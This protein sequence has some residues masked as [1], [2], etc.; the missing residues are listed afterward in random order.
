M[1]IYTID[2]ETYY[3]KEFSLSKLTTEQYIRDPRFHVILVVIRHPD[4]TMQRITGTH[5]EI[6]YALDVIPFGESAALAHNARFDASILEWVFDIHP[7]VWL[8]TL[9]MARAMFG[10]RGNGLA[11]LAK[12]YGLQDKTEVVHAMLGRTRESLTG[13]ELD[14]YFTYCQNDTDLCW[15]LYN[16]MSQGWYSTDPID[17]R[18]EYPQKELQLIDLTIKMYTRPRLRL[19]VDKLTTHLA[20]VKERKVKLLESVGCERG[21]LLSN[22]QFANLLIEHGVVPPTK[23]SPTTGKETFAF[24]KTDDGLKALAEHPDEAVQ[25]L[26]AA[27]L[28]VKSTLEETRTEA[29]IDIAGHTPQ[30]ILPIPLKY[31]YAVTKRFAGDDGINMQ[32]LPSR[33]V[34]AKAIKSCILAPPG[35]VLIDADSSNIEARGLAWLACQYD[36]VEDFRNKVD[37][38]N[39][40]ASKIYGREIRRKERPEDEQPGFVGKTVTLGCGYMTGAAKLQVTLRASTPS[41]D[42]PLEW[43]QAVIKTYRDSVPNICALWKQADTALQAMHDNCSMWLGREGVVYVDGKRG[44]RLPSGLY[45]HYP[46]LHRGK[47]GWQYKSETGLKHIYG[48]KVVENVVQALARIVV[49][50]QM[51]RIARRYTVSM[52]VHDSVIALALESEL[53]AAM[54]YVYEC[55]RWVPKWAT[56]WPLDCEA[57]YGYNYGEIKL[58]D[59]K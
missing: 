6:K 43:C 59:S 54:Q 58:Y 35:Y 45:I 34:N 10:M 8:D 56:G 24:A 9:S 11:A 46:Q 36:M 33:G 53:D 38:Y 48:G 3:D 26:V 42:M 50:E 57:K 28:G 51:L 1:D 47:E 20:A 7:K 14:Q 52:T 55:M 25:A 2:F 17:L 23:I 13:Y 21:E 22:Q 37:L 4:G 39:K 49:G 40:M 12:K 19:D 5:A 18:D 31:A 41:I 30:A 29:L 32:N 44:L 16:L 15:E 27:R